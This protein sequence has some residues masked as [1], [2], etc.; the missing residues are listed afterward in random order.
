MI[1]II[2]ADY[3]ALDELERFLIGIFPNG[4]V[5]VKASIVS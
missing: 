4:G 5:S 3:S 1:A 2:K